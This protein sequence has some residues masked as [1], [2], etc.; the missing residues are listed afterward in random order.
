MFLFLWS[1]GR[2]L[3][4]KL[5]PNTSRHKYP[6]LGR[7]IIDEV[8]YWGQLTNPG[9]LYIER[10]IY[11]VRSGGQGGMPQYIIYVYTHYIIIC[12]Y[13]YA[14]LV[15]IEEIKTFPLTLWSASERC[16]NG[17]EKE[18]TRGRSR[19]IKKQDEA[20]TFLISSLFAESEIAASQ[21]LSANFDLKSWLTVRSPNVTGTINTQ[22]SSLLYVLY[23]YDTY[24]GTG[25][26]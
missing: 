25:S 8:R 22:V 26:S 9:H 2:P 15:Q 10:Y 17:E 18:W 11:I 6:H 1:T 14:K 7:V 23:H 24:S 3:L 16:C 21:H 20:L 4:Y 5:G 19:N 12:Y 13:N